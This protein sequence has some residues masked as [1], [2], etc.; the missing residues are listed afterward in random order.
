MISLLKRVV[1]YEG[2]AKTNIHVNGMLILIILVILHG[3]FGTQLPVDAKRDAYYTTTIDVG[4]PP[5]AYDVLIDLSGADLVWWNLPTI[6]AAS[7]SCASTNAN[8]IQDYVYI[9]DTRLWLN[10]RSAPSKLTEAIGSEGVGLVSGVLGLGT[11]S[12]LWRQWP[13]AS[14]VMGNIVFGDDPHAFFAHGLHSDEKYPPLMDCL[15]GFQGPCAFHAYAE[16]H[17]VV[18]DMGSVLPRAGILSTGPLTADLRRISLFDEEGYARS[19]DQLPI[20]TINFSKPDWDVKND[21]IDTYQALFGL[22]V[23][24]DACQAHGTLTMDADWYAPLDGHGVRH[25][26]LTMGPGA[27]VTH[28]E[29]ASFSR[30]ESLNENNENH[31]NHEE[32][33]LI[34][35]A[36]GWQQQAL[37]VNKWQNKGCVWPRKRNMHLEGWALLALVILSFVLIWWI[38]SRRTSPE[39][40]TRTWVH[41]YAELVFYGMTGAIFFAF[42]DYPTT[43]FGHHAWA[44]PVLIILFVVPWVVGVAVTYWAIEH[45][46]TSRVGHE[47]RGVALETVLLLALWA[48]LLRARIDASVSGPGVLVLLFLFYSLTYSVPRILFLGYQLSQPEPLKKV[49]VSVPMRVTGHDLFGVKRIGA[50]TQISM[51]VNSLPPPRPGHHTY[52]LLGGLNLFCLTLLIV[53]LAF[54]FLPALLERSGQPFRD[55]TVKTLSIVAIL[56]GLSTAG[57]ASG[58]SDLVEEKMETKKQ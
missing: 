58:L 50:T 32:G 56:L 12:P 20:W 34:L 4:S 38:A 35:G 9:G 40:R 37:Y 28:P 53:E 23:T 24:E 17:A 2:W 1:F 48:V 27:T 36:K 42:L 43:M 22:P 49:M 13:S 54:F 15:P 45:P 25:H 18:L 11:G 3:S 29:Y 26:A 10:M 39:E 55:D 6:C 21:C 5:V 16:T 44:G 51:V 30:I 7:R 19:I 33:V 57:I 41:M 46:D 14:F 31:A 52:N 8:Q 47:L